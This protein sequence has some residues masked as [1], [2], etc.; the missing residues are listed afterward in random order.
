VEKLWRRVPSISKGPVPVP[1]NPKGARKD[2]R[3]V[4]VGKWW[5]GRGGRD[6]DGGSILTQAGPQ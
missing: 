1:I 2:L 5:G 3:C 6:D 4:M